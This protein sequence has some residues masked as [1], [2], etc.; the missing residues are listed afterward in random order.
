MRARHRRRYKHETAAAAN[1]LRWGRIHYQMRSL[2]G[3]ETF[4]RRPDWSMF[5]ADQACWRA[6]DRG[7][8]N[9]YIDAA[10][11]AGEPVEVRG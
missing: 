10:Q 4:P 11:A 6:F 9:G 3:M 7:M 5:R 8:L 2:P 1:G